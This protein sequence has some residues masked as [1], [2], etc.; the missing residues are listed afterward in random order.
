LHHHPWSQI[1]NPKKSKK[2]K[3]CR[4]TLKDIL[5][6]LTSGF[7]IWITQIIKKFKKLKDYI[8][9]KLSPPV[10]D[11]LVD[12][13]NQI[14]ENNTEAEIVVRYKHDDENNDSLIIIGL[15]DPDH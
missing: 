12:F 1:L 6:D 10:D 11:F 7:K 14:E 15:P 8:S 2:D 3:G 9:F 4:D 5:R 13:W